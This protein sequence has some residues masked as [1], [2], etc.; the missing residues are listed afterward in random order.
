MLDRL[1]VMIT[2]RD[3]GDRKPLGKQVENEMR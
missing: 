3:V 2:L 1:Y